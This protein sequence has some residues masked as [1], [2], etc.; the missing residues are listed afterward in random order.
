MSCQ[1]KII[2]SLQI[3]KCI[4][5]YART[6]KKNHWGCFEPKITNYNYTLVSPWQ[7][8]LRPAWWKGCLLW[9]W[10]ENK[11]NSSVVIPGIYTARL[12]ESKEGVICSAG[13]YVYSGHFPVKVK[14][15][16]NLK[17]DFMKKGMEKGGKEEKRKEW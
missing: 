15:R 1:T 17:E 3:A 14:N 7:H 9:P 16:K 11:I 6:D 5:S 13:I 2:P 12:F 10:N 8:V 4:F